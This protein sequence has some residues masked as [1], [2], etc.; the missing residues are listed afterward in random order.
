M[1]E[2]WS[3]QKRVDRS[4]EIVEARLISQESQWD[5]S[6]HNIYTVNTLDI[7]KVFKGNIRSKTIALATEGGAVGDEMLS[8]SPA[9]ELKVGQAGLF[10]LEKSG[11]NLSTS[12]TLYEPSSSLQS[13]IRY[14]LVAVNAFDIQKKYTS[15]AY[16]LYQDITSLTSESYS[17]IQAFDAEKSNTDIKALSPPTV[18]SFSTRT[19]TAGT[20]TMVTINGSNFGAVRGSGGVGFKDASYSDGRYYYPS[21]DWFYKLWTDTKIIV[22]VP[23]EASTG[24]VEIRNNAG[25]A[26]ETS[27]SLTVE[28]AHLNV[29]HTQ[30]SGVIQASTT[31]LGGTNGFGGYSLQFNKN[32]AANAPAVNSF[33]RALEE[34]RCETGINLALGLT[35]TLDTF[36]KDSVNLISFGNLDD[37]RLGKVYSRYLRCTNS[38]G[39]L[40]TWYL[41]ELDLELDSTVNWYFGTG[42]PAAGQYDFE[43]VVVHELGHGHQLGHIR[44]KN[45][46]MYFTLESGERNPDLYAV[47]RTAGLEVKSGFGCVGKI[48]SMNK[49]PIGECAV[50]P[51]SV[52][53]TTDLPDYCFTDSVR[54]TDRSTGDVQSYEW[55]FGEDAIPATS[56]SAG[57]LVI[58][59]GS[60]GDKIIRLVVSNL[61][62]SDTVYR[63][64]VILPQ[65][66]EKTEFTSPISGDTLCVGRH[67]HTIKSL[68]SFTGY[69]WK[70]SE[71]GSIVAD[72]IN[73]I[74]VDWKTSGTKTIE[75]YAT[76]KC[77]DGPVTV[78][79]I[80]I[81]SLPI[82]AFSHSGSGLTVTFDN[83]SENAKE[84]FWDFGDGTNST[85][86]DPT[87]TYTEKGDFIVTM[88]ATNRCGDSRVSRG[89]GVALGLGVEG[90]SS[91]LSLYPNPV[92]AGSVITIKGRIFD[93]F[94]LYSAEGKRLDEGEVVRNSV[95]IQNVTNGVYLLVLESEQ[96]I[97]RRKITVFQ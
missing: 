48:N 33:F 69:K 91:I 1:I 47:D 87:H 29:I 11:V 37:G 65:Y 71:G 70:V 32:L 35:T 96:G 9:L 89:M 79:T 64:V 61:K 50:M 45:S 97:V 18:T 17:V 27:D 72:L 44:A 75:V 93:N 49:V 36:K 10:L 41:S 73:T 54:L 56:S 13:F 86:I 42:F 67:L 68:T 7:Y 20:G 53:F 77:E 6:G 51:P 22:V 2:P 34:W 43:S 76:S 80:Y 88:T 21:I 57:P 39:T 52:S 15:I 14:D 26:G 30:P 82:A 4:S 66:T 3:L 12:S 8:V 78:Q 55:D 31:L 81:D 59:Y 94:S 28:W 92:K 58:S 74:R 83:K 95:P 63:T 62:G 84:Y 85:E 23:S 16:D 24:T 60:P 38:A 46:V 25:Q 40:N 19:V 90:V 5:A